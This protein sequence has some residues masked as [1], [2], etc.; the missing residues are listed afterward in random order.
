MGKV[1]EKWRVEVKRLHD[2]MLEANSAQPYVHD[3]YARHEQ[4]MK[5]AIVKAYPH[6]L[7]ASEALERIYDC[8]EVQPY[9][10]IARDLV[11]DFESELGMWVENL[12]WADDEEWARTCGLEIDKRVRVIAGLDKK[13][14]AVAT[15][16][17]FTTEHVFAKASH[18]HLYHPVER[19]KFRCYCGDYRY[20]T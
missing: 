8:G 11:R 19:G 1:Q 2:A 7:V 13:W 5:Q 17:R 15:V 6:V 4:A 9:E 3:V 12:V 14:D 20:E 10:R 18:R 16:A